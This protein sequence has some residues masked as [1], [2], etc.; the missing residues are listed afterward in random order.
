MLF[1]H[2]LYKLDTNP[3]QLAREKKNFELDKIK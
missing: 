1:V 3:P 2:M